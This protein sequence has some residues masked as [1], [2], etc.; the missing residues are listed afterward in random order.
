MF[1]LGRVA[2]FVT[3]SRPVRACRDPRDDMILEVAV[4][5]AANA[6]VT[7]DGDLLTLHPFMGV[8][9]LSPADWLRTIET[10]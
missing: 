6:I 4:N 5:G 2:E 10:D 7:G 3:I 9:I 1:R 8:P